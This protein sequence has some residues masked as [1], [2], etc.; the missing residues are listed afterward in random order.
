MFDYFSHRGQN[1]N[2]FRNQNNNNFRNQNNNFRNQNNNN[3][4][5]TPQNNRPV[6]NN[7]QQAQLSNNNNNRRPVNN[8][9]NNANFRATPADA[10]DRLGNEIYPGCNGTVCLPVAQ[11]CADR[12]LKG[13]FIAYCRTI[14]LSTLVCIACHFCLGSCESG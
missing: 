10:R 1:N 12:K 5:F 7:R 9:N 2:N 8:N 3:N 14:I 4:R 13:K 6:N 11:L